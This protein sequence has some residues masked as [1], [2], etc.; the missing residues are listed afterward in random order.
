MEL[1]VFYFYLA[2]SYTVCFPLYYI[3]CKTIKLL[4]KSIIHFFS[5]HLFLITF[6]AFL[7]LTKSNF[8]VNELLVFFGFFCISI[9]VIQRWFALML[10][11]IFV[12]LL[13]LYG[14]LYAEN[15]EFSIYLVVQLFVILGLVSS[16]TL[17][18][19]KKRNTIFHEINGQIK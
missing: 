17:H 13:L 15:L 7:Q 4:S 8:Q 16:L 19:I 2:I 18:T 12:F 9:I 1:P 3:L 6:I 10:Y 14:L 5:F 11:N